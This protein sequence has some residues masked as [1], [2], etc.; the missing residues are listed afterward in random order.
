MIT[1]FGRLSLGFMIGSMSH[2]VA[3]ATV[4]AAPGPATT[5]SQAAGTTHAAAA[6]PHLFSRSFYQSPV[7]G[8]PDDLLLL[9]G[10]GL[11][12]DDSVIYRAIADTTRSLPTPDLVPTDSGAEF[13]TADVVSSRDAPHSL[14]IKLPRA[15]LP[16]Q[17]YALWVRAAN[18]G[19]SPPVLINDAR[20][21]WA[22]PAYVYASTMPGALPRELK[23]VGRN[24]RPSP[25]HSTLIRLD[26]PRKFTLAYLT[27]SS[28]TLNDYV[29]RGALPARLVPGRYR[30]SVSRDGVGWVTIEDQALEV[31]PDPPAAPEFSVDDPR[32]GGCRPD[33]GL[34]DTACIVRA[35]A[36]ASRA[37]GGSV[38]FGPG[39]WNIIDSHQTGSPAEDGIVVPERVS[40]KGAGSA[41]T[42]VQRHGEWSNQGAAVFTL[43]GKTTVSGFTF[44]DL[45][46]Y[47]ARDRAGPFLQL[48][49]R[50]G[51]VTENVSMVVISQNVFDKTMVA[52][53]NGSSPITRLIVD[54][55]TFG[56]FFSALE[57]AGDRFDMAHKYR[58]D[59][60][61]IAHNVFKPGSKLDVES[62]TGT[63]ASELGAGLRVDF[64]DNF[65]DGASV[66]YLNSPDDARGWRAAFFWNLD[67]NVEEVLVSGNTATCTGDK[68]GDGEAIAFDNNTNTFA[69]TTAPVVVETN[70]DSVTVSEP[71]VT[72]QSGE[73][74]PADYYIDHW[75]QVV[76]GP[77]LGQTRRIIGY[78]TDAL[79]HATTLRVAPA[80][81]VEPVPSQTR[82]SVGRQFWQVYAVDNTVDNRKPLCRKSNRSRRDAGGIV[83]WAES[84]DSVIAGNHQYDSDG[85]L[86]QQTYITPEHLCP[87]CTMQ[88]FFQYFVDVRSNVIDGEYDWGT[89]C[90]SS[91]ITVGIG[92][93]PWEAGSPPTTGFGVSISHNQIRRADG[94]RGGAIGQFASWYSGP[95]PYRWPLSEN[96]LVHHNVISDVDGADSAAVCGKGHPRVGIAFPEQDIAWNTILYA[97]TCKNVSSPIGRSGVDVVRVCSTHPSDSC[98][99]LP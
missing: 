87:D 15:L 72:R 96:L 49:A 30:I 58:L 20:P 33:D 3:S 79:S 19:W 82:I 67:S 76:S 89:D 83:L 39:T 26:G 86:L 12:A 13:G 64:S 51:G 25:N 65:A 59:D 97:N 23:V 73:P 60:G 5:V 77:G 38:Y 54:H 8:D 71:M 80:W 84:A 94:L 9:A 56:A 11:A 24:L 88:G 53:A 18:G 28:K 52:I 2:A 47:Q 91:G 17:S 62:A 93:A 66:D 1:F 69:F 48:G 6:V 81:D 34:D 63:L 16:D 29:V 99:C 85:I 22:S 98:E 78:S 7:R 90:S 37:G 70:A 36:A 27:E 74:V 44:S 32:F 42:R 41:L 21:L 95:A 75:V 50:S 45:K 61:I 55:D 40:L 43:L 14:T 31:L 10:E 4:A 68:V 57:L 35:V 92:A 46:A